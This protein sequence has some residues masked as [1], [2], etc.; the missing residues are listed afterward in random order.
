MTGR[1][2]ELETIRKKTLRESESERERDSGN[3]RKRVF[4]V[5]V[6][7]RMRKREGNMERL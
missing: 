1:L 5:K 7:T 2:C 3:D 4:S 6:I